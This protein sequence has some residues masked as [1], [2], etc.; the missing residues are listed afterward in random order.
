MTVRWA[1]LLV[2]LLAAD[3]AAKRVVIREPPIVRAC[4]GGKSWAEVQRCIDRQGTVTVER[5]LDNAKL[6]HIVQKI[7]G[8]AN[9]LGIYLYVEAKGAW[10]MGGMFD[11]S[12]DFVVTALAP[13]TIAKHTG[14]RIDITTWSHMPMSLDH[15]TSRPTIMTT[16]RT[17]FCAGDRYGCADAITRCDVMVRGKVALTFQGKL[18]IVGPSEVHV[19]G[20]RDYAGDI[21]DATG[22]VFIG[23]PG[24]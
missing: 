18:D 13:L 8:T 21:C 11:A 23:W 10:H 16:R 22:R 24:S 19:L 14:F 7:D 5:V 12:G 2:L 6:V 4:P 15:V 9:D 20:D 1:A 3:A 17:L